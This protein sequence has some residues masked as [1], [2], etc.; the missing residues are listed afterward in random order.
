[1]SGESATYH[2]RQSDRKM[3]INNSQTPDPTAKRRKKKALLAAGS[4]LGVGAVITLAAWNDSVWGDSQF[5]TGENS[6]NVQGSFD[7]GANW[8]EFLTQDDA[9]NM[10]FTLGTIDP[11]ALMPGDSVHALV[12]LK[13]TEGNMA[14]DVT[15]QG[16]R[17]DSTNTL[18]QKLIVSIADLGAVNP[19]TYDGTGGS[20][21]LSNSAMA[22]GQSS[23]TVR[24]DANGQKWLGFT[25]TLPSGTNPSGLDQTVNAA[26]EM[27]A[28]SVDS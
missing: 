9:G 26:W 25:V 20:A 17:V 1:M 13:E 16:A 22:S 5:G 18:G 3:T 14:A 7:A 12:G 24:V 15:V 10:V 6:W 19:G 27:S 28:Q 21:I 2:Q 8:D 11:S 23:S 4:V